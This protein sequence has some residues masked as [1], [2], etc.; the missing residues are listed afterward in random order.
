MSYKENCVSGAVTG[1]SPVR[2]TR[3]DNQALRQ[4]WT[5]ST[6]T[7][8]AQMFNSSCR[9]TKGEK[10]MFVQNLKTPRNYFPAVLKHQRSHGWVIEYY[11]IDPEGVMR[12]MVVKM[13]SM[14]KRF[15][16]AADFKAHCN[17][18]VCNINAKLAG[19]WTPFGEQQNTRLYTP[20]DA[21]LDEYLSEK[22]E[23]LRPDTMVNYR[24]FA[25]VFLTWIN[26]ICPGAHCSLFNKVMAVKFMDYLRDTHKLSG[27]AWNNRLKQARAFFSWA[28]EKCYVAQNPFAT[29][30]TKREQPKKRIMIPKDTRARISAYFAS[31]IPQYN[32]LMQLVYSA[33]IR[34]KEAWRLKIANINLSEG[35][36]SVFSEESKTHYSRIA[37]LVPKLREDIAHM[38]SGAKQDDYLFGKNYT[39]GAKQ[40]VYSRF[41]KEWDTMRQ[42]LKLPQEMQ[43]YSLRDT[44]ITE[45]LKSGIDALTVMQHA[46]H[47]DLSMTTRYANHADPRLVETISAKAPMF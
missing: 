32:V 36:I 27:R 8:S 6:G 33:L 47:H 4:C 17:M 31:R 35:Y 46:D 34:P 2:P 22:A 24:S 16:L 40:I 10:K 11:A 21:V 41:R 19:G 45:M 1:S 12:R 7:N 15:A 43:L 9:M 23:E 18:V 38:I 14:R 29:I 26:Q 39:P 3:T 25:K 20:I 42:A 13:N 37:T 44:G 30:K 5:V 28:L